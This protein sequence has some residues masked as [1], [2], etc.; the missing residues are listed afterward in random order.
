MLFGYMLTTITPDMFNDMEVYMGILW[1][2]ITIDTI[3]EE[4]IISNLSKNSLPEIETNIS[5]FMMEEKKKYVQEEVKET[6]YKQYY[7]V[8]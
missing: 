6:H 4:V 8:D 5:E 3:K 2:K 7:D 1:G